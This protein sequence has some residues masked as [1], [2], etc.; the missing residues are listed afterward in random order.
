MR[1]AR[2]RRAAEVVLVLAATGI[3]GWL[4]DG[5][6]FGTTHRTHLLAAALLGGLAALPG[7]SR[8]GRGLMVALVVLGPVGLLLRLYPP[9]TA[10]GVGP[11]LGQGLAAVHQG[12]SRM[13]TVGLPA[14]PTP[15]LLVLPVMV[16]WLAAFLGVLLLRRPGARLAPLAPPLAA[17]VVA[18][19]L[20][21]GR[22]STRWLPAA[23]LLGVAAL[24][25]L[26]R[27]DVV[28]GEGRPERT[29]RRK[30]T[31]AAGAPGDGP[32]GAVALPGP[33]R[34]VPASAVVA[35]VAAL[36]LVVGIG[37]GAA[38]LVPAG[39][40]RPP[41]DPRTTIAAAHDDLDVSNPLMHLKVQLT[42][43]PP[44]TLFTVR[45]DAPQLRTGLGR[46]RIAALDTFTGAA[47]EPSGQFLRPGARITQ[48][49]VVKQAVPATL[50]VRVVGYQGTFL[51]VAGMPGEVDGDGLRVAVPQGNLITATPGEGGR[52]YRV[53]TS[54]AA[55][56]PAGVQTAVADLSG[57]PAYTE[58]P[59]PPA[60][61][62]QRARSLTSG[63]PTQYAQLKALETT[64]RGLPYGTAHPP[65]ESYAVLADLLTADPTFPDSFAEQRASAFAVLARSLGFPTRVVAGYVLS[66]EH[67]AADGT[68]AVMT[69]DAHAWPEVRLAGYGWVAFEPTPPESIARNRPREG[70]PPQA[71]AQRQGRGP[72]VDA[73]VNPQAD[74]AVAGGEGDGGGSA[75]SRLWW[76]LLLVLLT[77]LLVPVLKAGRRRRRRSAATARARV[78]G[79]WAEIRD[80]LQEA[81]VPRDLALTPPQVIALAGTV[82]G[83]PVAAALHPVGPTVD[84]AACS[85]VEPGV[86]DVDR[87]WAGHS[88]VRRA[89]GSAGSPPA[90]WRRPF[91]PRPLLV[92]RTS[93]VPADDDAVTRPGAPSP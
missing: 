55:V 36:L 69:D 84:A 28:T 7:R 93:P 88:H 57:G 33:G 83:A 92:R 20:T 13:I 67:R 72:Q 38:M 53:R 75:W 68:F 79:A 3:A 23:L 5:Y 90:R 4:L 82:L 21:A 35:G 64:L 45:V 27:P 80:R 70:T 30:P 52:E 66:P 32:A 47:W 89:L 71:E 22:T 16:V 73:P 85:P 81:G 76:L 41:Y 43:S 87:A 15:D 58:L 62:V 42:T 60:E 48:D 78:L 10:S 1:T 12:W 51:P 74:V 24:L 86:Q 6:F 77:P 34:G 14:A 37:A 49:A 18:L 65:G 61:L 63:R 59:S 8:A 56:D 40:Q 19:L 50:T 39:L 11:A 26:V 2:L 46:V 54:I 31:G 25:V 91:D 17:Y 9:G 44:A 29:G